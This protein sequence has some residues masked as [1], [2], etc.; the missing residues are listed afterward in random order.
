MERGLEVIAVALR[1]DLG[2]YHAN[3]WGEHVNEGLVEWP[4][5]PWRIL[6]GLYATSRMHAQLTAL[7]EPADRALAR[8]IS[9]PPPSYALPP[10]TEGH[11]RHYMP[12]RS[13]S[14]AR[15]AQDMILDA[16]RAVHPEDEVIVVWEVQLPG[17]EQAALGEVLRCLGHLGRSE[18]VCSAR[19]L[20]QHERLPQVNARPIMDASVEESVGLLCPTSDATLKEIGVSIGELR[21]R[22]QLLPPKTRK[23][24]YL[25]EVE[26]P[27]PEKPTSWFSPELAFFHVGGG[28]RPGI[29][30]AV[31]V[32]QAA[33]AA[34]QRRYGAGQEGVA[35]PTLSGRSADR[36]RQ[37]Q[38]QHAH[39]LVL[40]DEG[41]LRVGQLAIWAPEGF[42]PGEIRALTALSSLTVRGVGEPLPIALAA[43]GTTTQLRIPS[44]LGPARRWRSLTPFGLVRH[45]KLRGGRLTDGPEEQVRLELRRRGLPEPAEVELLRGSW[46]RFRSSRVGQSRLQQAR[47]FGIRLRFEQP[48]RG[49]IAL[50]A[51]CHFGLG[52]FVAERR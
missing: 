32:A 39:Y 22:R 33:R 31:T 51:L 9:A 21:R 7:R 44:L 3:P 40:P 27:A 1:F 16:F 24:S 19:L 43:I 50:G 8:L 47:V 30:E 14:W 52:L 13:W 12:S 28:N 46:H 18:S 29:A 11:T 34:L 25:V 23:V 36:P 2:R 41:G 42:G 15:P 17:D 4:P 37:D 45:P 20:D 38:H 26:A 10:S 6:R 49:P 48:V 5:S 35:S